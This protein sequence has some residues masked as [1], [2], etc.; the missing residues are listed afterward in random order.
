MPIG[1]ILRAMKHNQVRFT[2]IILEIAITLAIV[3][4]A[5]NMIL[6]QRNQLA[7]K[8]GF[9]DD[10]LVF[11]SYQPYAP[12]FREQAYVESLVQSDMRALRGIPGVRAVSVTQFL[13]WQGGGSSGTRT[14]EGYPGKFQTQIYGVRGQLADTLGVQIIKGRAFTEQDTPSDPDTPTSV[15]IISDALAKKLWRDANPIGRVIT[16]G[17]GKTPRTVVGV[18]GEFYNPYSWNIGEYVQFT[19]GRSYS[20]GGASFLIR[21]DPGAAASVV[22][23]LEP[24][25]LK[26]NA[27]RVFRTTTVREQKETYFSAGSLVIKAMTGIIFVLVFITAL[28]IVG[29]TSLAV[30]ERTKQIG[31]RRAL[32]ATRA[33]IVKHFLAENWIVTTLGLVLGILATY[34]LNFFLVTQ[35][36]QEKLPWYLVAVGMGLLWLNGLVATI[37]PA[38]RAA[39]VPPAIATRSV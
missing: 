38:L 1:P 26:V 21:T 39:R 10:N 7:R 20:T 34:G 36:T 28:G 27:G 19:P 35:L 29:I 17:E 23:Q 13:P 3:S 33:D 15:T 16:D 31:T 8:S 14:T 25:L 22:S 2:L 11:V 30:S 24:R 12:E 5:V 18:I 32:G 37:P 6:D 9:D 4:N